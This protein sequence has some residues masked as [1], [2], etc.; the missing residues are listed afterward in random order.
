MRFRITANATMAF[1]ETDMSNN[2]V[3]G[4]CRL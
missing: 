2:T 4:T 3:M 1:P